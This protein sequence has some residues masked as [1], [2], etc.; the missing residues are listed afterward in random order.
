MFGL[1]QSYSL[2]YGLYT[3]V[4]G[5][6]PVSGLDGRRWVVPSGEFDPPIEHEG[7]YGDPGLYAVY[8]PERALGPFITAYSRSVSSASYSSERTIYEATTR[9][10]R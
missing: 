10:S 5:G 9:V 6:C 4:H 7:E 3:L 8:I 1:N 2:Q